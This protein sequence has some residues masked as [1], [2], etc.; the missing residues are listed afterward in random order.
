[1]PKNIFIGGTGRS[2]TTVLAKT[3]GT[4]PEIYTFPFEQRFHVD[5]YGL[6]QIWRSGT[7]AYNPRSSGECLKKFVHLMK[8]DLLS[9]GRQPY[10]G[11]DL[12]RFFG[13]ETYHT[14]LERLI[15]HICI[16]RYQ[17]FQLCS[18]PAMQIP[19]QPRLLRGL[20]RCLVKA[21]GWTFDR[22]TFDSLKYHGYEYASEIYE[23][24]YFKEQKELALLL[25]G[26]F[27]SLA[28]ERVRQADSKIFCEH[29]PINGCE[30]Q[31]IANAFP[32]SCMVIIKRNPIDVAL[33]YRA[34]EWAPNDMESICKLLRSQYDV[35]E[36]DR[37]VLRELEY[38]FLEIKIEDLTERPKVVFEEIF[39]LAE[40]DA[41]VPDTS[42]LIR[43][44]HAGNR[45]VNRE[46]AAVVARFFPEVVGNE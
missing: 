33:S 34:Q 41:R 38:S 14:E 36:R 46:D 30:G 35:W 13:D 37:K 12:A 22:K 9:P 15:G 43:K 5:P 23:M 11:F 32:N 42:H 2:G 21:Y 44:R 4:V 39:E 26:F 28:I 6:S 8:E 24:R 40:L 27:E 17:G 7:I 25:G 19:N 31:F 16:D 45:V 3:L 10:R 29:T 18:S 20:M 1:M